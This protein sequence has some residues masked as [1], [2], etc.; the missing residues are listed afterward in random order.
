MY[1]SNHPHSVV[2]FVVVAA[3]AV[4]VVVVVDVHAEPDQSLTPDAIPTKRNSLKL[5]N[6]PQ[7]LVDP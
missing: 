2:A 5:P 6:P 7:R 1:N 4:A 3:V